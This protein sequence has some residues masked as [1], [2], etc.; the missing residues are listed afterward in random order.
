MGAALKGRNEVVQLLVDRGARARYARPRQ[1]RHRQDR[2]GGRRPHAGRRSTTPTGWCASA[3]SR[4]DR[5]TR[6]G[7]ADP[8]ADDRARPSG[9][10]A[11]SRHQSICVVSL[12]SGLVTHAPQCANLLH[13][14]PSRA[15]A[16]AGGAAHA[17]DVRAGLA[18]EIQIIQLQLA[19][20]GHLSP[21]L[22]CA[23]HPRRQRMLCL[24]ARKPGPFL[25]A[26]SS[27]TPAA[28]AAA[29][30]SISRSS[31]E[32]SRPGRRRHRPQR[33]AAS[34]A[35]RQC[36][37]HRRAKQRRGSRAC[38][39]FRAKPTLTSRAPAVADAQAAPATR[40][41]SAASPMAAVMRRSRRRP[42]RRSRA[43]LSIAT[44]PERPRRRVL[45][46]DDVGAAG[47]RGRRFVA[48]A[49]AN[50]EPHSRGYD[51]GQESKVGVKGS[52]SNGQNPFT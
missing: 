22:T 46:V 5:A 52:K 36:A 48:V 38:R 15:A 2:L 42:P 27:R 50:E 17:G 11:Q 41:P 6:D 1:P 18:H 14:D 9:A 43:A 24:S 12:L 40:F 7:G 13:T 34:I 25:S 19:G 35:S 26:V 23:R 32:G 8:Q 39:R 29:A 30:A 44:A 51:G 45:G 21:R 10:A 3:C 31:G 16:V 49:H 4:R 28:P 37:A 33:H 20:E 47:Q